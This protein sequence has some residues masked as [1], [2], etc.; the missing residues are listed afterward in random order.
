V[1]QK[2]K[3]DK[4]NADHQPLVK[5]VKNLVK[6]YIK[7]ENAPVLLAYSI[8]GDVSNSSASRILRNLKADHC[9]I[10]EP[11]YPLYGT[12]LMISFIC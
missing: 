11:P 3:Q 2:G 10:S 5:P 6:D 4:P 8:E 9:C 7:S 1:W 12:P